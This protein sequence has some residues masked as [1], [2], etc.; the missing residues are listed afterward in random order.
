MA[1]TWSS[2]SYETLVN[3]ALHTADKEF[4]LGLFQQASYPKR[5]CVTMGA[6][7]GSAPPDHWS[8]KLQWPGEVDV[9][10][11]DENCSF[12]NNH[13]CGCPTGTLSHKLEI[14][15]YGDKG[16]GIRA[17]V[18]LET[19]SCIGEFTGNL[20]PLDYHG[21]LQTIVMTRRLPSNSGRY[22]PV[23]KLALGENQNWMR[24]INCSHK[25]NLWIISCAVRGRWRIIAL[26]SSNVKPGEELTI[27]YDDFF[28]KDI[29]RC[30]CG[31]TWTNRGV[32]HQCLRP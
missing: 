13:D 26:T 25:P 27:P 21:D 5:N 14:G 8:T 4:C 32:E 2:K 28:L 24:L 17:K 15:Y 20:I 10:A 9:M 3:N 19:N 6:N 29:E 18:A 22:V 7:D 11:D 12:C 23:C 1:N 16:R 31:E 30:L